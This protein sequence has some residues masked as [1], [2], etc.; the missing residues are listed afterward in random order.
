MGLSLRVV[1]TDALT[2]SDEQRLIALVARTFPGEKTLE[3]KWHYDSR[4]DFVVL[5]EH[6]SELVGV[7]IVVARDVIADGRALRIAGLGIGVDPAHQRRGIGTALTKRALD[8]VSARGFDL[9]LAF[10]FTSNSERLLR[11]HGFAPLRARVSFVDRNGEV[12]VETSPAFAR[13]LTHGAVDAIE[14]AGAL[15]LGVGTW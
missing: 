8:E 15:D 7:R 5:A 13:A 6:E 3:N 2:R 9:A 11:A 4:P 1:D 12:V 10:L 14:R